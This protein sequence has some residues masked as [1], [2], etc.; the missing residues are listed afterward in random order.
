MSHLHCNTPFYQLEPACVHPCSICAAS[1]RQ[2]FCP[3]Y[4]LS[5]IHF[6]LS[7]CYSSNAFKLLSCY[8]PYSAVLKFM[9]C[10]SVVLRNLPARAIIIICFFLS[11]QTCRSFSQHVYLTEKLNLIHPNTFWHSWKCHKPCVG[12]E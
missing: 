9:A 8:T 3:S 5:Y 11:Q 4:S 1:R 2:C 6:F 7:S 12:S 10:S